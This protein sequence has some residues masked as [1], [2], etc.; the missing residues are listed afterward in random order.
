LKATGTNNTITE[1]ERLN[2]LL[3]RGE[4]ISKKQDGKWYQLKW[5]AVP[6]SPYQLGG[7]ETILGWIITALAI[8]LGAPFWFDLLS[9]LIKIR[10][11]G[12]KIGSSLTEIARPTPSSSAAT[13]PGSPLSINVTSNTSEEAVG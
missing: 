4:F 7:W 10:G 3:S 13:A 11:T 12:T 2:T 5:L 9:R 1:Y 6:Y 8:M